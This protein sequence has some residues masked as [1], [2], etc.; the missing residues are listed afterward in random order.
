[1]RLRYGKQSERSKVEKPTAKDGRRRRI[2]R[3]RDGAGSA[4]IPDGHG[5]IIAMKGIGSRM[6]FLAEKGVTS[7][8][9]ADQVDPERTNPNIPFVIQ[10]SELG[11]GVESTF[12]QKTLCVAFELIDE[13]HLPDHVSTDGLLEIA[14]GVASSLAEIIDFVQEISSSQDNLRNQKIDI[15]YLPRTNNLI[16]K[17][18]QC[19]SHLRDVENAIKRTTMIFY[20]KASHTDPWDKALKIDAQG[21]AS[22]PSAIAHLAS[23]TEFLDQIAGYRHA[24][25]HPDESKRVII[26]DYELNAR[27]SLVAPTIE[28]IH[29]RY[30]VGRQDVIQFLKERV[31]SISCVYESFLAW[32]CNFN[33]RAVQ[34]IFDTRVAILPE[35]ESRNGSR[36]VWDVT[37]KPGH[38]FDGRY[39]QS[40][41]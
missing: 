19:I 38:E 17:V 14:L 7:A 34:T 2:D 25:I 6:Y 31:D 10:R 13:T 4:R 36:L 15:R 8:V 12:V 32:L 35:G 30:A 26:N 11:Y 40:T 21:Y 5:N 3:M 41:A 23:M 16:G 39:Q 20:P 1:M 33:A 37:L 18:K 24:M 29:P 22:N 28:I 27:G 9:F